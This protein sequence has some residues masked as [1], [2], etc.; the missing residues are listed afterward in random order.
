MSTKER[1]S[2]ESYSGILYLH[3]ATSIRDQSNTLLI[4]HSINVG[5]VC[6]ITLGIILFFSL[7]RREASNPTELIK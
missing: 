6:F 1:V 3:I 7:Q 2:L 4:K 5:E